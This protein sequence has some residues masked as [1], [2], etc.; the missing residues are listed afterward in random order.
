MASETPRYDY[1]VNHDGA[2]DNGNPYHVVMTRNGAT[3][4]IQTFNTHAEALAYIREQVHMDMMLRL[5]GDGD[6]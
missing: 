5:I 2:E 1:I 3:H 6:F 4:D